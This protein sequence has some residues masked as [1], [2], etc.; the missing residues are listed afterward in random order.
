MDEMTVHIDELT[1]DGG[2]APMDAVA[3][4]IGQ[5]Q[6]LSAL[7]GADAAAV[8]RAVVE[9]FATVVPPPSWAFQP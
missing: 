1:L 3:E 4:V 6:A 5:L 7:A 9:S 2:A 8:G